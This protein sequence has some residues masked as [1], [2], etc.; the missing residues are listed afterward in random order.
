MRCV[1]CPTFK[2]VW[3]V[4]PGQSKYVLG[5]FMVYVY[6]VIMLGSTAMVRKIIDACKE[7]WLSLIHI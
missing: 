7:P 5:F 3:K 1:Q 4:V 2:N 6:D